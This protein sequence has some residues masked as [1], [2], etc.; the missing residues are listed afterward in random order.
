MKVLLII[1][2]V[3]FASGVVLEAQES[4]QSNLS[5][6]LTS[7]AK[8]SDLVPESA[9][10]TPKTVPKVIL[11]T[12]IVSDETSA[13]VIGGLPKYSPPKA[14]VKEK[15]LEE[16]FPD[17]RDVDRPQNKI[18]RL[19]KY[20]VKASKSPILTEKAIMSDAQ[21]VAQTYR[22][23]AG[24][25]LSPLNDEIARQ[26]FR[27][28]LRLQNIADLKELAGALKSGGDAS[29]SEYIKRQS[30]ETYMRGNEWGGV[31]VNWGGTVPPPSN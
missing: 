26:F 5:P 7:N 28:D 24:L 22:K 15:T 23:Y 3:C 10:L 31:K 17:L 8:P 11:R 21:K 19:P 4:A 14:E 27:E 12:G 25:G 29:E 20:M 6:V 30:N 13:L 18:I 9:Q 1:S 16:E 2:S